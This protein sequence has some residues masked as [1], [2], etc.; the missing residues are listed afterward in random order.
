MNKKRYT[1]TLL[2]DDETATI[3]NRLDFID[4]RNGN[5]KKGKNLS[6][7]ICKLIKDT[8]S[9]EEQMLLHTLKGLNYDRDNNNTDIRLIDLQVQEVAKRIKSIREANNDI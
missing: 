1:N 5:V 9:N 3:L 6:R 4:L 7:F 2:F 8:Y